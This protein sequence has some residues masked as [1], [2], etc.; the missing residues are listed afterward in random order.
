MSPP[1][2]E[3]HS[4]SLRFTS[5]LLNDENLRLSGSTSGPALAERVFSGLK[6]LAFTDSRDRE[7]Q[8]AVATRALEAGFSV[9][10]SSWAFD[11]HTHWFTSVATPGRV[12]DV[13]DLD[14]LLSDYRL[15]CADI[16]GAPGAIEVEL[17]RLYFRSISCF[18]PFEVVE[19][20]VPGIWDGTVHPAGEYA[21]TGLLLGYPVASTVEIIKS[22]MHN[23]YNSRIP[24]SVA[25]S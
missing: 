5:P 23:R 1:S 8:V 24:A 14:A 6:P 12:C 10:C 13:F 7:Q 22:S 18:L 3:H 2:R 15:L 11:T 9:Q 21:R 16:P 17:E 4:S 20:D 25:G 19:A